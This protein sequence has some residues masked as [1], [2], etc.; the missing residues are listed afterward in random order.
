MLQRLAIILNRTTFDRR[1]SELWGVLMHPSI[2]SDFRIKLNKYTIKWPIKWFLVK[3]VS[4]KNVSTLHHDRFYTDLLHKRCST[5]EQADL[6]QHCNDTLFCLKQTNFSDQKFEKYHQ[7][8]IN[9]F[10]TILISSYEKK[11]SMQHWFTLHCNFQDNPTVK[12]GPSVPWQ[13]DML[14]HRLPSS[15]LSLKSSLLL[16]HMSVQINPSNRKHPP[17]H[18]YYN[19]LYNFTAKCKLLI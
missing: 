10:L 6:I 19:I 13:T 7:T 14:S 9:V 17:T 18:T 15:A 2:M 1:P 12:W 4:K 8:S 16:F 11:C 3:G 5:S